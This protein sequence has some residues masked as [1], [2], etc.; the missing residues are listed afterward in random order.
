[1]F[2]HESEKHVC[3]HVHAGHGGQLECLKTEELLAY[4]IFSPR[5][6]TLLITMPKSPDIWSDVIPTEWFGTSLSTT[7]SRPKCVR[8][9]D[10]IFNAHYF[11]ASS[12]KSCR[13]GPVTAVLDI[14]YWCSIFAYMIQ[15]DYEYPTR[16]STQLVQGYV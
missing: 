3:G 15:G 14:L 5:K 16:R 12:F 9:R 6:S 13:A 1:M 7:Q 2:K 8:S 11:H 4:N 10:G